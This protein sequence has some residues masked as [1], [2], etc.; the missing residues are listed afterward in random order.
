MA[1]CMSDTKHPAI[2]SQALRYVSDPEGLGT[3]KSQ[4]DKIEPNGY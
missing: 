1:V 2:N 4:I 3:N